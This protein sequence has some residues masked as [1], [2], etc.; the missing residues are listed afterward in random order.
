M[1]T[2]TAEIII[3]SKQETVTF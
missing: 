1:M 3:H 2:T